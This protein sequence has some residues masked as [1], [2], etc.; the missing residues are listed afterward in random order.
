MSQI[1]MK[2]FITQNFILEVSV[3]SVN[4]VFRSVVSNKYKM[5][6]IF[7]LKFDA[8]INISDLQIIQ[9]NGPTQE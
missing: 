6:F 3:H 8:I 1:F 2:T 9:A 5:Q 4:E 7:C